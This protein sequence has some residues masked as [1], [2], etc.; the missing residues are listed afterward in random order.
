M[1]VV[2]TLT[3][4][5]ATLY[6][7]AFPDEDLVPLLQGLSG[8]PGTL[9]LIEGLPPVAHVLFTLGQINGAKVALLGPAAVHPDRQGQGLGSRLI[10]QGIAHLGETGV[11]MVLVL[12]DPA[13]YGRFGF[14][15]ETGAEP[16]C[17]IPEDWRPAW[18]SL[19]LTQPHRGRLSLPAPW[20]SQ[21]L[22]R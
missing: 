18:Q 14:L 15:P 5:L 2:L 16:P 21:D 9:S 22:W 6:A 17:P 3:P 4:D 10:R 11:A 20:L 8:Q 19:V 12:G 13:Y 1:T 7:A